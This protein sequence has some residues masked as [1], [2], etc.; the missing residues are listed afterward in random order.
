MKIVTEDMALEI[1]EAL[2]RGEKQAAIGIGLGLSTA[3]I[4]RISRGE[5]HPTVPWPDG[6]T[7]GMAHT[8]ARA[9]HAARIRRPGPTPNQGVLTEDEKQLLRRE[10]EDD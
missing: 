4:S 2:W 10:Q 8:Q 3:T 1:K 9:I 5:M 6:S 7:G